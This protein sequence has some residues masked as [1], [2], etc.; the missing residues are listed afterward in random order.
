MRHARTC[1]S[2]AG[3]RCNCEPRYRGHVKAADGRKI[4]SHWTASKAEAI[5]WRQEAVIA[6]RQGRLRRAAP[7]TVQEAGDALILP[8]LV[9][10]AVTFVVMAT[11]N[12][13]AYAWL[14]GAARGFIR[15]TRALKTINRI[16]G[17]VLIGAGVATAAT[18]R[19][20]P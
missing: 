20:L 4:R 17:G 3:R 8:Q 1:A 5:A 13:S 12:A 15:S 18:L 10:L 2:Q 11:L 14:A 9:L 16:G 7:T 6:V 19:R